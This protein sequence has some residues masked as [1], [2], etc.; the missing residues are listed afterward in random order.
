MEL[1]L[2]NTE[3]G[4]PDKFGRAEI[5]NV[6]QAGEHEEKVFLGDQYVRL[7]R[8]HDER[9]FYRSTVE[10]MYLPSTIL[11]LVTIKD[12]G[13]G[14]YGDSKTL[15][16]HQLEF[17][18]TV[19]FANTTLDINISTERRGLIITSRTKN[20]TFESILPARYSLEELIERLI[21]EG[22]LDENLLYHALDNYGPWDETFNAIDWA[23]E[24]GAT[25]T[26]IEGPSGEEIRK[27]L[28]EINS[29]EDI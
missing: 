26:Q 7:L 19:Q 15:D 8:K 14:D 18:A 1:F 25:I 20:E 3:G 12:T 22:K 21:E 24:A 2:P 13:S 23:S 5:L 9:G 10:A 11:R 17:P 28:A 4:N 16:V 27:L 29:A 6:E